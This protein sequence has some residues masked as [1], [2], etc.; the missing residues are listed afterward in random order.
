MAP[1]PPLSLVAA[2]L[3]IFFDFSIALAGLAGNPRLAA[4]PYTV[5]QCSTGSTNGPALSD[6]DLTKIFNRFADNYLLLDVPGA[7]SP[8]MMQCCHSGCD[9]CEFARIFDCMTSGR[10]KWVALYSFRQ[11]IDGRDHSPPWQGVFADSADRGVDL[12]TFIERVRRLPMQLSIGPGI[13]VPLDEEDLSADSLA[14]LW[15]LLGGGDTMTAAQMAE[16]LRARTGA[17]HGATWVEFKK[18][19]L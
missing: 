10:V 9:N 7:G 18:L 5:L 11:L 8:G 12:P 1:L 19:L 4:S 13:T 16:G 14:H 3:L 2:L 17:A 15:A 6:R